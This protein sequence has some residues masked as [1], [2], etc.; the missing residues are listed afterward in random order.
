MNERHTVA[1]YFSGAEELIRKELVWGIVREPPA[2]YCSHQVVV[3]RAFMLLAA[4]AERHALGR[5]LVSPVDVVLDE[6]KALVVQPDI[7]YV[8]AARANII[9]DRIWGVP[10]LVV[11]VLSPGTRRRDTLFK[12]RWYRQ[13]GVREY[14]IIDPVARTVEVSTTVESGRTRR[15]TYRGRGSVR[16]ELLTGFS[17]PAHAFFA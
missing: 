15:H 17:Q 6:P 11:E 14:W 12:R 16:S 7:V 3:G 13:Y 8:A 2:P 10:D 1:E 5:V 9:R 4:H